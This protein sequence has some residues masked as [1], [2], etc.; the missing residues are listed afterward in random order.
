PANSYDDFGPTMAA[1]ESRRRPRRQEQSHE[2]LSPIDDEQF[3]QRKKKKKRMLASK[4][5]RDAIT[6]D[7]DTADKESGA[8]TPRL[9]LQ[10]PTVQNHDEMDR[11]RREHKQADRGLVARECGA[12][13]ERSAHAAE[14][15]H[16]GCEA[17]HAEGRARAL[18]Q[19]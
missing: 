8:V 9:L 5:S 15:E 3:S 2:L 16:L 17:G 10:T 1:L 4:K 13:A 6:A 18:S 14:G 12:V 19:E 11:L 7:K